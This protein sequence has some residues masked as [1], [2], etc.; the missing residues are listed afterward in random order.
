MT[1]DEVAV[2]RAAAAYGLSD[3]LG[4]IETKKYQLISEQL[5]KPVDQI[6]R[7]L[8]KSRAAFAEIYYVVGALGPD[9]A[10]SSVE[11]LDAAL[12]AFMANFRGQ[13][14]WSI[15]KGAARWAVPLAGYAQVDGAAYTQAIEA[16]YAQR[17]EHT[18]PGTSAHHTSPAQSYHKQTPDHAERLGWRPGGP[19]PVMLL[20]AVETRV[21]QVFGNPHPHCVVDDCPCHSPGGTR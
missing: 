3:T 6:Q 18:E 7:T 8:Y 15:L 4:Y 20:H 21:A 5:K 14:D 12:S 11:A 13:N 1:Q 19:S 10:F 16:E 9:D 17:T 2:I